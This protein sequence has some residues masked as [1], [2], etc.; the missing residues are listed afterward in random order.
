MAKMIP[1]IFPE[2]IENRGERIFYEKARELPDSYTVFYSYKFAVEKEKSD[3]YGLREA[4]FVIVHPSLGFVVVEVKQGHV[5]YHNGMWQ[6]HKDG[7][8]TPLHKDPLQQ[9][10]NAMF[11]ILRRYKQASNQKEFPLASRFALSFPDTTRRVGVYPEDLHE[12]SCWTA[13]QLND[14]EK[15]ITALFDH[16]DLRSPQQATQ[17]LI[18][19]VLSPTFKVFSSL[20]DEL[21]LFDNKAQIVLTEEQER[22][23]EETEEDRRKIFFG[24]AGTGKTFIA[25]KKAQD[26]AEQGKRVFLTCFNKN[27]VK[28]F[29]KF[30]QHEHISKKN[31]HDFMLHT[32]QENQ[33]PIE[34]PADVKEKSEFYETTLPEICFDLYS[35]MPEENKFDAIIVDEGQDFKEHWYLCLE[36]MLKQDGHFYIFAD[37]NQ[38]L[39]GHG[40]DALKDFQMSTHKL[41]V[42]LRNTQRINDWAEPF[43]GGKKIRS[44]LYGGNP[45]EYVPWKTPDEEKRLIQKRIQ[46]LVSQGLSPQRITILSPNRLENSSL[47]EMNRIGD[48][49]LVDV[50]ESPKYGVRFST[51]RA[52]KGLE[53]DVVFLIGI[54][55]DSPV[56]TPE[57]IYV[58]GTRARFMLKIFHHEGWGYGGIR[59]IE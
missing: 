56:C 52:F 40:L 12:D 47:K 51:I 42:N 30:C 4:D 55:N 11:S 16:I 53:A 9:A 13:M 26:L 27:L 25:M 17:Q 44:R 36:E 48:W 43:L 23:L 10:R 8:F 2:M 31:F 58:G 18:N 19:Q 6:V 54:K 45:V 46:Q 37:R 57:D 49:P 3:S 29:E 32:L 15:S 14:L 7:K 1:D 20:E 28:V 38:N 41:T 59:G 34:E 22:I 33:Y 50:R 39:F 5:Y 35:I 24:A 21:A